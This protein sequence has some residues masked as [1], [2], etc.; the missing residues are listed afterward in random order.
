MLTPQIE[1]VVNRPVSISDASITLWGG[2]GVRLEGL[3]VGNADGFSVEPM[4]SVGL[5]DIK[6]QFWPLLSGRVV[7]DRVVVTELFVLVEYDAAGKSNFDDVL[8][9]ES[10][11][12]TSTPAD[13]TQRQTFAKVNVIDA[14]VAW[15]DKR[16]GRWIDLHGGQA[17]AHI[18]AQQTDIPKFTTT[19]TFDSL[20]VL[21]D[22]RKVSIRAGKPSLYADGSWTKS[23]RT[24]VLDSALAE[25][26]G[27]Q[28][29]ASG[30]VR[31]MPSLYEVAFN[32]RL[33]QARVE[34]LIREVE[35]V[36]ELPKLS[37]LTALMSG[38]C[39]A[40]FAWP[41]PQ[42]SVP[43]WQ[44]RFELVDVKWPLPETDAIV[45]IPR[46][47]IRGAERS[48][49][50]SASAGQIT[51]G[52]FSSSGTIDQ[53]FVG[54]HT[55]S[56]RLQA[57]MPLEGTRGL[58]PEAWRL[59]L[60]GALDLDVTGFGSVDD[61]ENLHANGRISS[62]RVAFM[63]DDW[64]FDS[65]VV[66]LDSRLAGHG[67]QFQRCNVVAGDSRGAI[68][69]R[70]ENLLPAA[71]SGFSIPDVP[72]GELDIV[73]SYL[74]L[75]RLIGEE[76]SYPL[77][78]SSESADD[79][80]LMSITGRLTADSMLYNKL[81]ITAAEA[82]YT[83]KDRV[84]SLTPIAGTVFGGSLDGRLDWNLNTWPNPE[85]FTSIS[86]EGIESNDFFSRY[87]GYAGGIFGQISVSGEFSGRGREAASII[88]TLLARGRI[89]LSGARIES[90][91]LLA[92]I[93]RALGIAGLDKP[94]SLNDMRLPF[95]I[96]NGRVI[97]DD[98][99]VVWDDVAYSA[100]GS[101]G[102]DQTLAY[103]VVAKS[104][105]ERAPRVVQG[106]GL[107]FS[108]TGKATEPTVSIDARG[109]AQDVLDNAVD[110][111]R[112]TLQKTLEQKLKDILSPPRT[113]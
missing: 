87:L 49:S 12:D 57:N 5:L 93:G 80:P 85:F 96:E 101:F 40:Q 84:F 58:M 23:S 44:G 50:W 20:F 48:V 51:G 2:I 27:A 43:D 9:S 7:M 6:S 81:V 94:R 72:H 78:D 75:D 89:D 64:E 10:S 110:Q 38:T 92:H 19:I 67:L 35:S 28:L 86:A 95:R 74:D 77:L 59:A 71:L 29:A 106:I 109:T 73:C 60:S 11:D 102:L 63:S 103:T 83:Y 90:A 16:E 33:G 97:T 30:Q 25:W 69:G 105:S 104:T 76:S 8:K 41:L 1:R 14:R 88:P 52:T 15:R 32:A 112:D 53:L 37:K 61:W 39:E 56:A 100:R 31:F 70:I 91:P 45:T 36:I 68:T 55:F 3:T 13:T 24:L 47:E 26:W 113:P 82:P 107:K 108:V 18:D 62:D 21:A 4:L 79:F 42:N 111:A 54:E 98:L 17:E 46:V 34:E 66:S 65:I 99:N 22:E